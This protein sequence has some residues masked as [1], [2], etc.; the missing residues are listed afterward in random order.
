M[1]AL[2]ACYNEIDDFQDSV[3]DPNGG[4]IGTDA[5]VTIPQD[6]RSKGIE[7]EGFN[8]GY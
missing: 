4:A 6:V 1:L 5:F 8:P 2:S 3:F 7:A